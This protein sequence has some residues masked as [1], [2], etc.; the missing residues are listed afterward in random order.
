MPS[1]LSLQ[2]D[3]NTQAIVPGGILK[4]TARWHS[5]VPHARIELRLFWFTNG[6]GTQDLHIIQTL[7]L[8]FSPSGTED[9]QIQLPHSPYSMSGRLITLTWA[10]ELVL[11]PGGEATRKE[12]ILSP[13]G[14][15]ILLTPVE[16]PSTASR[17][18]SH[19]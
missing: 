8:P 1:S 10:L 17:W 4:G 13:N 5:D 6:K 16:K 18:L 7:P 19:P 11:E 9:F 15:E 2:L 14:R 3:E 12:F